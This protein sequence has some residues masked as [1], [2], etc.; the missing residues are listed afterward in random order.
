MSVEFHQLEPFVPST[1]IDASSRFNPSALPP[2]KEYSSASL[3]TQK[4][5]GYVVTDG[6]SLFVTR[7]HI[8]FDPQLFSIS[9][10]DLLLRPTGKHFTISPIP[11]PKAQSRN[12]RLPRQPVSPTTPPMSPISIPI[13]T[14]Q[15]MRKLQT[16]TKYLPTNHP[17]TMSRWMVTPPPHRIRRSL[18]HP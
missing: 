17:P 8:T 18:L 15:K 12:N 1:L 5:L 11:S 14:H 3:A 6:K 13:L 4:V 2:S 9:S 10:L 16:S 7:D